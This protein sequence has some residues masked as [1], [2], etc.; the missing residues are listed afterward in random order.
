MSIIRAQHPQTGE[1]LIFSDD[2]EGHQEFQALR[3]SMPQFDWESTRDY[4]WNKVNGQ[5]VPVPASERPSTTKTTTQFDIDAQLGQLND[6]H[7]LRLKDLAERIAANP[8]PFRRGSLKKLDMTLVDNEIAKIVGLSPSNARI[9][10]TEY[11]QKELLNKMPAWRDKGLDWDAGFQDIWGEQ[12]VQ[13]EEEASTAA[14]SP[15]QRIANAA[16]RQQ[17]AKEKADAETA[18]IQKTKDDERE[19]VEVVGDTAID[20]RAGGQ[21]PGQGALIAATGAGTGAGTGDNGVL[22]SITMTDAQVD[23]IASLIEQINRG[24]FG[25][26]T[27]RR[28]NEILDLIQQFMNMTPG[29]AADF[30]ASNI[31]PQLN[32]GSR[33]ISLAGS[34]PPTAGEEDFL[35]RISEVEDL[36]SALRRTGLERFPSFRES[37]MARSILPQLQRR[38]EAFLPI[39]QWK[40]PLMWSADRP[41]DQLPTQ[42]IANLYKD[43][44]SGPAVTGQDLGR[45]LSNLIGGVGGAGMDPSFFEAAFEREGKE[46]TYLPPS[47]RL[48]PAFSAAILPQMYSLPRSLQNRWGNIM[49]REFRDTLA[50]DPLRYQTAMDVFQDFQSRGF[51]PQ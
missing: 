45:Q 9:V 31:D 12:I 42:R 40:D 1:S 29:A 36:P 16:K 25:E 43:F 39:T 27:N 28:Q 15:E 3:D 50:T 37:S 35:S 14:L 6:S 46:G 48:A 4:A 51:I 5:L 38:F 30:Y 2:R 21:T 49:E 33:F 23:N 17:L 22:D 34:T 26:A 24:A 32:V 19:A 18:Y 10:N 20:E 41:S 44:L 47:Q 13:L 7:K 11:L 8:V